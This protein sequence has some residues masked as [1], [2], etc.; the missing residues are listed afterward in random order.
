VVRIALI[1][2]RDDSKA[3]HRA[4]P[5]ALNGAF[6]ALGT[7]GSWDWIATET[8]PADVSA[9]LR[10]YAGVWCV[11][12][13]P[14]ANTDGVLAAIQFARVNGRTFLGTCGGFQHT[15]LEYAANVWKVESPAH[16]ETD[17]LANDPVISPLTCSL[18]E[19]SD[20]LQ[21]VPGTR[22][23][24]IYGRAQITEKYHCSYGLSPRY[25]ARLERGAMHVAARDAAGDI[26]GVELEGHPFYIATLFQPERGALEGRVPELPKAFAAAAVR[27]AAGL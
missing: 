23:H 27:T 18:V 19:V 22:L 12:G 8:I 6:A 11:P 9:L 1:G 2:D 16:A 26:R 20:A 10:P 21:L 25:A 15:L 13:S 5:L 14:Y 3:A 4:I 17:P 7:E 24:Q